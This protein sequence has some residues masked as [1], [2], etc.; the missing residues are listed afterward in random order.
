MDQPRQFLVGSTF[1]ATYDGFKTLFMVVRTGANVARLVCLSSFR[2]ETYDWDNEMTIS[3][4]TGGNAVYEDDIIEYI[5]VG[6]PERLTV[7]LKSV[8]SVTLES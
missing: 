6:R 3:R 4:G 8:H 5:N 7:E 2:G 1:E